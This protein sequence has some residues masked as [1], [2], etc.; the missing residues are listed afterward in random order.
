[1][2]KKTN[3]TVKENR[4]VEKSSGRKIESPLD[5][6]TLSSVQYEIIKE[7]SRAFDRLNAERGVFVAIHPWGDTLPE[8]EILQMLKDQ[9]DMM[10]KLNK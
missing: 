5:I 6:E 3:I 4:L 2:R 10:E 7:I 9:N 8:I 1:M